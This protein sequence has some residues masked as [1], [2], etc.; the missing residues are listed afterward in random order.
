MKRRVIKREPIAWRYSFLSIVSVLLLGTG[1]LY[2]ARTHFS[3]MNYSMKNEKLRKEIEELENN[4]RQLKVQKEMVSS[5]VQL[6]KAAR[7]LGF[8]R[9]SPE[10]IKVFG[11]ARVD[12]ES[13]SSQTSHKAQVREKTGKIKAEAMYAKT[14]ELKE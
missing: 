14:G 8:R 3:A 10:D 7:R 5:P 12:T 4:Q 2:A 13:I 1:F 11:K 6:E 9:M